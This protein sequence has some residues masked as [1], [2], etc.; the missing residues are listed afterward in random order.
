MISRTV[1]LLI[2]CAFCL[3]APRISHAQWILDL[4]TYT[5]GNS[6]LG[7]N[8]VISWTAP[9]GPITVNTSAENDSDLDY[10]YGVV[11][12][13]STIQWTGGGTPPNPPKIA[14]SA[15][16]MGY[17]LDSGSTDTA[18]EMWNAPASV[19][20]TL[21]GN[22]NQPTNVPFTTYTGGLTLTGKFSSDVFGGGAQT[23]ATF[24]VR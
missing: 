12:F 2:A 21:S 14:V 8:A 18:F 7:G 19:K 17:Q 15:S 22:F 1:T 6:P 4:P 9:A 10:D 3:F 13:S 16:M 23:S 5:K 24:S 11:T 20:S